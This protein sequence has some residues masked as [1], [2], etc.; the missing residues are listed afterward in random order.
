MN[1]RFQTS[2]IPQKAMEPSDNN[3]NNNDDKA[4][5]AA[6][7]IKTLDTALSEMSHLSTNAARN[8]EDAR[9]TARE[10]SEVA[11]RYTARSYYST[12]TTSI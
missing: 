12:S 8:V 2:L 3:N 1:L 11:R 4:V 10:A 6:N 9:R 7:L 5:A